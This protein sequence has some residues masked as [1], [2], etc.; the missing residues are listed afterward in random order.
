MNCPPYQIKS[1]RITVLGLFLVLAHFLLNG[2]EGWN[3]SVYAQTKQDAAASAK[4]FVKVT[5]VLQHPRCLNCH[6]AG[7]YPLNGEESHPHHSGVKRGKDGKG[8]AGLECSG[9]HGETNQPGKG[10][11][12]GAPGWHLPS[13][14]MPMIF[15]N[16]TP[17]QICAQLKD[18]A[19]NGGRSLD[20]VV[21]HVREHPLVLWGW[22]PGEGR[23]VIFIP[24][25]EFVKA[26][27]DWV[28]KGAACPKP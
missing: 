14:K 13:E 19:Q 16:R 27:N 10:N 6:P 28:A 17:G 9:C 22:K 7:D 25:K 24:H 23:K 4:A 3:G 18:P 1:W 2:G 8:I 21:R 12:P 15:Q 26:M 20:E 11:P 5:Q